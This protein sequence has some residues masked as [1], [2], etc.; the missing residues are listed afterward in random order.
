MTRRVLTRAAAV[1]VAA[2]TCASAHGA[3][4]PNT[5]RIAL[6]GIG[7]ATPSVPRARTHAAADGC[8]TTKGLICSTVSV[9]LDRSGRVPGT[10]SLRVQELPSADS[11]QRGAV[12]LVAG[13]PGQGSADSFALGDPLNADFYRYMFPGYTL[14]A[15]DDR[16]TGRSGPLDCPSLDT[17]DWNTNLQSIVA[18]CAT[19]LGAARDFYGTADHAEDLDAVRQALGLEKIAIWGVS[20]GT[21][22]ALA[23]ASAHPQ[24]VER[25]VLDSV[26]EPDSV[27]PF[28]THL[29]QAMPATLAAY[30]PGA[31]CR[32]AT[33]DFAADVAAVANSLART[34]LRGSMREGDGKVAQVILGATDFLGMVIDAD[35]IPGLS[36]ELPAAVNAARAGRPHALLRLFDIAENGSDSLGISEA[37][38]LATVCRDGPFPWQPDTPIAQRAAL[39]QAALAALP[40]GSFGPFAPWAADI[41]NVDL[42]LSWPAPAGGDQI[43]ALPDV[44]VLAVSGGLDMRTPTAGAAAVVARFP[45]GHLLVVPGV[46]HSV[47]SSD[48]SGC[49]QLALRD[50]IVSGTTPGTCPRASAYLANAPEFAATTA[51]HLNAARTRALTAS[52]LREAEAAWLIG[53]TSSGTVIPG[54]AGGVLATAARSF[55][56]AAYADTPGLSLTGR[57]TLADAIGTPL[58]F[59]GTVT[60]SGPSAAHGKLRLTAS[61]LQGRL[62]G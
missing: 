5:H 38:Y 49:S 30:C 31:S 61:G 40:A 3:I 15:Y 43:G 53:S 45:Q 12:F 2:A 28:D 17:G 59:R 27:D 22:L 50:W 32:G 41:G 19:L 57:V 14:V 55:V 48:P 33:T 39:A 34:P 51:K 44:P 8:G 36:A 16:G 60:V 23:Y 26:V 6:G 46:G 7:L 24:H 25:L 20:Y 54:I 42:C 37:L 52:T 4:Q 1:A 29:L 62:T 10:I 11:V 58:A 35:L 21:K 18:D 56:L 9:P 13:G 47:L